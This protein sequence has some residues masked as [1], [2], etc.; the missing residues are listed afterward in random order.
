MITGPESIFVEIDLLMHTFQGQ[1]SHILIV[2]NVSKYL[3]MLS[4]E[5][6]SYLELSWL[7]MLADKIMSPTNS[8]L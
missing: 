1:T 2:H 7:E 6:N 5:T 8:I 3:D 4:N